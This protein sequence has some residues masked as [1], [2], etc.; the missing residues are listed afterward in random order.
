MDLNASLEGIDAPAEARMIESH[1]GTRIAAFKLGRGP[2][3]WVMPP[4]MGAPLLGVKTLVEGLVDRCTILTWDMRGFFASE[5]ARDPEAYRVS[6]HIA[7][8]DAV[9]RAFGAKDFVLGGWSM[10]V[11][12]AL[13][14]YHRHPS[15]VR[16][17]ILINGPYQRAL[18]AVAPVFHP[19]LA[20][21]LGHAPRVA[22]S[23]NAMSR[24]ILGARGLGPFLHRARLIAK[25]PELMAKVLERFCQVDWGRY[26][27][28]TRH[29]H[30]HSAEAWLADVRVPTLI[31]SGTRDFLTPPSTAR[32][33]HERIAGSELFIVPRATH[34]IPIEFGDLLAARVDGFLERI[35]WPAR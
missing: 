5:P 32:K 28:V 22:P 4:A 18:E 20:R 14:R 26:L 12:L 16:A 34:Y 23:L 30:D 13:E 33:M 10:A 9:V 24:T 3:T 7:D 17:L 31:T 6:D 15:D 11:Q 1:D 21:A 27:T 25:N 35:A 2:T 19:L 8:L 29:L